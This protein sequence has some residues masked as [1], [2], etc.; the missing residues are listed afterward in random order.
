MTEEFMCRGWLQNKF[1]D[2]LTSGVKV[3][4]QAVGT[5]SGSVAP[6]HIV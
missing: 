1:I 5:V 6:Q 2:K 3:Y 4:V